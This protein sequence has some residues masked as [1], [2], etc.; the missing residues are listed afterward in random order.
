MTLSARQRED[1]RR[2]RV[3]WGNCIKCPTIC[4]QPKVF[5]RGTFSPDV[6]FVGAAPSKMDSTFGMPFTDSIG[7]LVEASMSLVEKQMDC[8]VESYFTNLLLCHTSKEPTQPQIDSCR[9]RLERAIRIVG[10]KLVARVGLLAQR[11]VT[12]SSV[13]SINLPN[14]PRGRGASGASNRRLAHQ[15]AEIIIAAL[16]AAEGGAE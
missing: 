1:W 12:V 2:H 6:L 3:A 15:Y 14:P 4:D 13:P 11:N 10:P 5:G 8:I 9:P 16:H 7:R